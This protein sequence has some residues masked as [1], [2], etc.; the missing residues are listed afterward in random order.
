M[1]MRQ[2]TEVRLVDRDAFLAQGIDRHPHVRRV[3][4]DNRVHDQPQ[5][6]QLVLLTFPIGLMELTAFAVED[7]AGGLSRASPRLSC[8]RFLF[9]RFLSEH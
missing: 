2:P 1:A 6:T 7:G 8:V 9:D 4:Q 5:G 3:P